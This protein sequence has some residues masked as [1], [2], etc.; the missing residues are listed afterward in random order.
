MVSPIPSPLRTSWRSPISTAAL[1]GATDPARRHVEVNPT[2][3]SR[4]TDPRRLARIRGVTPAMRHDERVWQQVITT[5]V[6]EHECGHIRFTN[7]LP[8]AATLHWLANS[9]TYRR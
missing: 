4:P 7:L 1:P 8:Q 2:S 6:V 5:A 9:L 3:I